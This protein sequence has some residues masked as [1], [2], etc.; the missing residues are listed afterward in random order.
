MPAYAAPGD[1]LELV[2][3]LPEKYRQI[4]LLYYLEEKSYQQVA[5]ILDLPM[6]TVKTHLHRAR[7]EL[8]DALTSANITRG[9]A[10]C[11]KP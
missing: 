10:A 11:G 6:G 2:S 7:K 8:A 9:G 3:G 1:I 4:L 5:E